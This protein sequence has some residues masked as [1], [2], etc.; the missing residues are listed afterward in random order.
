MTRVEK[1]I[2][3]W[4]K[5]RWTE[6]K[7]TIQATKRDEFFHFFFRHR[8]R[9]RKKT[10]WDINNQ[11][12]IKMNR[13]RG[14]YPRINVELIIFFLAIFR[15]NDFVLYIHISLCWLA[16]KERDINWNTAEYFVRTKSTIHYLIQIFRSFCAIAGEEKKSCFVFV[17]VLSVHIQISDI[18]TQHNTD[19]CIS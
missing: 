6:S 13:S 7:R 11:Q 1:N 12:K 18:H 5:T 9:G 8:E 3:R 19:T 10:E 16:V 14:K 2:S 4:E 17:W 15:S